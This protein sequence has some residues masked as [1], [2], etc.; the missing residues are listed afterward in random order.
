M[1]AQATSLAATTCAFSASPVTNWATKHPRLSKVA[2]EPE[3]QIEL[4]VEW[5][6]H[7]IEGANSCGFMNA[8]SGRPLTN[9]TKSG[10]QV[11]VES[12]RGAELVGA[13]QLTCPVAGPIAGTDPARETPRRFRIA[14]RTAPCVPRSPHGKT[15]Q[16]NHSMSVRL[17]SARAFRNAPDP[18]WP[19][20]RSRCLKKSPTWKSVLPF[21]APGSLRLTT[22]TWGLA[23]P[24]TASI[25]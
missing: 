8:T 24:P 18:C 16:R 10:R 7:P 15:G 9:P 25:V 6:L 20:R 17:H 12:A 19:A 5:C 14:E 21:L 1:P 3:D 11:Y 2:G 23:V 13:A 22:R 4:G